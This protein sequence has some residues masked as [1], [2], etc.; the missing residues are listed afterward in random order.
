MATTDI[1][2]TSSAST[3]GATRVVETTKLEPISFFHAVISQDNFQGRLHKESWYGHH[4]PIC[5]LFF[6]LCL[7]ITVG[8][9]SFVMTS[10]PRREVFQAMSVLNIECLESIGMVVKS[11]P[12]CIVDEDGTSARLDLEA[13]EGAF[14]IP[15]PKSCI[16]TANL[17]SVVI[18]ASKGTGQ[19][20]GNEST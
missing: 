18:G 9:F 17:V 3:S 10:S 1:E 16:M 5:R 20:F 7:F 8:A 13:Y 6:F 12:G 19:N 2:S 4:F 14:D 11:L 15:F